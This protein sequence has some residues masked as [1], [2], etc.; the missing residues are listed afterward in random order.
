MKKTN[1]IV[2][3][4]ILIK[5][6]LAVL[7]L[8]SILALASELWTTRNQIEGRELINAEPK[9]LAPLLL[10]FLTVIITILFDLKTLK[11][12]KAVVYKHWTGL[13]IFT[14]GFI[15]VSAWLKMQ[16]LIILLMLLLSFYTIYLLF[17]FSPNKDRN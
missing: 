13:I 12:K 2:K 5:S 17:K 6:V 15:T 7:L 1:F 8:I 9:G 10:I 4:F 16:W 11:L 3:L 14:V